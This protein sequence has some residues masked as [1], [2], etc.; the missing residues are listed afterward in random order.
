MGFSGSAG[1]RRLAEEMAA[2]PRTCGACQGSGQ[3][4]EEAA[5]RDQDGVQRRG[6]VTSPCPFCRGKGVR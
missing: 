5:Y 1:K 3:V 4:T 6:A 2:G